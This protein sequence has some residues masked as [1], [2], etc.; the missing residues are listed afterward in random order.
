M[1]KSSERS[2]LTANELRRVNS[3]LIKHN[4]VVVLIRDLRA[5][6]SFRQK[7]QDKA[8]SVIRNKKAGNIVVNTRYR[9]KQKVFDKVVKILEARLEKL[10][11]A[12]VSE[13][14]SK[15]PT[16]R[17]TSRTTKASDLLGRALSVIQEDAKSLRESHSIN[18]RLVD[19][20]G[21][22]DEVDR[23]ETLSKEI[24][25]FLKK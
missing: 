5:I 2:L 12:V 22:I 23:L 14:P 9:D 4:D 19:Q 16:S 6:R 21:V 20:Y 25:D 24:R 7:S 1:L 17:T 18:G 3:A 11:D 10:R 8:N 15:R 13:C